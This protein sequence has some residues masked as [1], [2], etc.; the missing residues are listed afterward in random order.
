VTIVIPTYNRPE[1]LKRSLHYW[2]LTDLK[3]SVADGSAKKFDGT[4]PR[5]VSYHHDCRE[6][7]SQ[8][9]F[10]ALQKVSTPYVAIC[11][12]D[13][14][15][16]VSGIHTCVDF[17]NDH[18]DYASAQGH[19]IE[20][21]VHG[22][23]NVKTRIFNVKMIGH[24]IDGNTAAE[25]LYQL[26]DEYIYQIYS[27]YRTPILQ[28]AFEICKDQKN[29]TYTEL[30]AAIIPSI[31]GKH[32][33]LPVFFSARESAPGSACGMTEV[34]RFDILKPEGLLDYEHWRDK[35]A[36]V[37]SEAEDVSLKAALAIVE[38]TFVKYAAWDL[39]T[40]PWRRPL[41]GSR[42]SG[43]ISLIAKNL[44]KKMIPSSLLRV[45]RNALAGLRAGRNAA[46][47]SAYAPGFP[48]TDTEA[49]KEW[50]QMVDIILSGHG[51]R[52]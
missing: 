46:D 40:F 47:T 49:A 52:S 20:F 44:L 48:W 5:N 8:R 3:V 14:F 32:R 45:R 41:N 28:L 34:P 36:R 39:R 4:I 29:G 22:R 50:Q 21:K 27:L 13:D 10:T 26:F 31:F 16:S 17:L 11:A 38:D 37:Y 43:S 9:W 19:A 42:G 6:N 15:L 18:P 2:G 23:K 35:I 30:G 1:Y 25:R 33:V 24:H 12:D 51:S 7:A